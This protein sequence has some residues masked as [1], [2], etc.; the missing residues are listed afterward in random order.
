M[1]L[2]LSI[3]FNLKSTDKQVFKQ[4]GRNLKT[5][6]FVGS[7]QIDQDLI[8][9]ILPKF[10]RSESEL[11]SKTIQKYRDTLLNMILLSDKRKFLSSTNT[12]IKSRS[13]ELPMFETLIYFFAD[14]LTHELRQGFHGEYTK[15]TDN[16]SQMK[17]RLIIH[18]HLRLNMFNQA[19]LYVEFETFSIDNSLMQ[20]F[21]ASLRLLS[22]QHQ[23]GSLTKQKI[24]EAIYLLNDV[25]DIQV[26]LKDFE[27][28][29]FHRMNSRFED[30]VWILFEFSINK[31]FDS[32]GE[33]IEYGRSSLNAN[34]QRI[35]A[36]EIAMPEK[37][38]KYFAVNGKR[39][40]SFNKVSFTYSTTHLCSVEYTDGSIFI[41]LPNIDTMLIKTTSTLLAPLKLILTTYRPLLVHFLFGNR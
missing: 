4:V 25:S 35:T 13:G 12:A 31:Q 28:I 16:L 17:G 39:I 3:D 15:T 37:D 14:A 24:N 8:I 34:I 32:L 38:E 9:E 26:S 2:L 23:I 10:I 20:I 6:S 41:L 7:I 29:T 5:Q 40:A 19:K 11:D 22:K 21:K 36:N 1:D 18:E 27:T 30:Q 33:S